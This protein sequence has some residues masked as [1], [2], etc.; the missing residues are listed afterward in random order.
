[1][2]LM[3]F[4]VQTSYQL[5]KTQMVF[6]SNKNH[7]NNIQQSKAYYTHQAIKHNMIKQL[8]EQGS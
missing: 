5:I 6:Y 7:A 2:Q 3:F 8:R 4:Q 1:M